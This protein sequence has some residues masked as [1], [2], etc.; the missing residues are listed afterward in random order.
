MVESTTFDGKPGPLGIS[1]SSQVGFQYW[2]NVVPMSTL[3]R[4]RMNV[5]M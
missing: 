3:D 5:D 2:N 4:C 1:V